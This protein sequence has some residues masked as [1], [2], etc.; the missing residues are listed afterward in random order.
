[1]G[2]MLVALAVILL[3]SLEKLLWMSLLMFRGMVHGSGSY[4]MSLSG[5]GVHTHTS[6]SVVEQV[7]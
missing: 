2:L 7:G 4:H 6:M 1:M 5:L 3:L